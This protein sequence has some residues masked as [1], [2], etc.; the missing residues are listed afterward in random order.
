MLFGYFSF[1]FIII[2]LTIL[3][4]NNTFVFKR[5]YTILNTK[6]NNILKEINYI[7]IIEGEKKIIYNVDMNG[8]YKEDLIKTLNFKSNLWN[9]IT[10]YT[11]DIILAIGLF[12]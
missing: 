11:H 3:F 4:Y 7:K 10:D 5:I 12:N 8:I 1:G 2:N 6:I 9:H